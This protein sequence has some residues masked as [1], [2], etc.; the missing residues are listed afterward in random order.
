MQSP[1]AAVSIT[2][3]DWKLW[4]NGGKDI[5]SLGSRKGD[6]NQRGDR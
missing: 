5:K 1:S 2:S 3:C 6:S 4:F